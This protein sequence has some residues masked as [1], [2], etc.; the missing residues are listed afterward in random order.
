MRRAILAGLAAIG[1]VA[2]GRGK[3]QAAA[4]GH[5]TSVT[6]VVVTP[7]GKTMLSRGADKVIR[8][9]DAATVAARQRGH[10]AN[11]RLHTRWASFDQ[12]KKRPVVA[13]AAIAR[14]L[15]GWSWSLAVLD[16]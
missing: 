15:A 7:D 5:R 4:G 11:H 6:A 10:A 14:E 9:W 13:N 8:R 1:L 16:D 12:R 3:E 2:C